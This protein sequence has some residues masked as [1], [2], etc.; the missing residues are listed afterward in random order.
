MVKNNVLDLFLKSVTERTTGATIT[1][2]FKNGS[3][4]SFSAYMLDDLKTDSAVMDIYDNETGEILY[5]N[6]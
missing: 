4:G 6:E 3:A 1:A 2:R 5:I